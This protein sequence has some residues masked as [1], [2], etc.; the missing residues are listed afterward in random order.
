MK[1]INSSKS[2]SKLKQEIWQQLAKVID[3]ELSID[4]VS[5]GLVYDVEV[6]TRQTEIGEEPFVHIQMT[7]TTPGCPLA[8]VFDSMIKDSLDLIE[9]FNAYKQTMVE[10]VFDPP[11]IPDMMTNEAKAELGLD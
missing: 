2:N 6:K 9:G 8:H 7:L 4:I 11:W 1:K 3:P 5:M 10:L